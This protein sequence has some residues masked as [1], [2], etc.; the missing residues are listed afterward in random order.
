MGGT[1]PE[2]HRSFTRKKT[3]DMVPVMVPVL[4][5]QAL[6]TKNQQDSRKRTGKHWRIHL[7]ND[8][9]LWPC[10]MPTIAIG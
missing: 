6:N 5:H 8:G 1:S 3:G 9:M 10:A 4:N 7:K 2:L